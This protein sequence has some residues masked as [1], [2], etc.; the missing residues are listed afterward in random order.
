MFNLKNFV[1][2]G[3]RRQIANE[4]SSK[5]EEIIR[6]Q[7]FH[8]DELIISKHK[9]TLSQA[10]VLLW[11][12]WFTGDVD[13]LWTNSSRLAAAYACVLLELIAWGKISCKIQDSFGKTK[14]RLKVNLDFRIIVSGYNI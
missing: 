6:S 14:I 9:V 12:D 4:F 5:I 2:C 13:G 7:L 8:A 3:K 10:C 1:S 11:R